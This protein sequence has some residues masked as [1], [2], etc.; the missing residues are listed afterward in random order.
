MIGVGLAGLQV[1]NRVIAI[2][3]GQP[4]NEAVAADSEGVLRHALEVAVL[5]HNPPL[6]REALVHAYICS[7]QQRTPCCLRCDTGVF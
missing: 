4:G 1:F 3:S 7:V 2:M 5:S 6:A